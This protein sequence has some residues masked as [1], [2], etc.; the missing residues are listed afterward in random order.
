MS[1]E[2]LYRETALRHFILRVWN[3]QSFS[4]YPVVFPYLQVLERPVDQKKESSL[5]LIKKENFKT[6]YGAEIFQKRSDSLENFILLYVPD[7]QTAVTNQLENSLSSGAFGLLGSKTKHKY[8]GMEMEHSLEAN[9]LRSKL[10]SRETKLKKYFS[11][12][13]VCL[14]PGFLFS[15]CLLLHSQMNFSLTVN[16]EW[17][18]CM[19]MILSTTFHSRVN[20][21]QDGWASNITNTDFFQV[22]KA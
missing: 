12:F 5:D 11:P 10:R 3:N 6:I 19:W 8:L 4:L 20:G 14:P 2:R 21:K 13:D 9:V 16:V 7:L 22:F 18:L 1:A 15:H 17:S